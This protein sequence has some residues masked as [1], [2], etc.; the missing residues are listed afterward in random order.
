MGEEEVIQWEGGKDF[1]FSVEQTHIFQQK[2]KKNNALIRT[3]QAKDF[4]SRTIKS[5]TKE[6]LTSQK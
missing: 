1:A 2:E 6:A 4:S 3:R 5:L